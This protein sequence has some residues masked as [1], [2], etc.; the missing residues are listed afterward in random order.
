[1][2]PGLSPTIWLPTYIPVTTPA[3]ILDIIPFQ[4]PKPVAGS[5]GTVCWV[6]W[7]AASPRA[8]PVHH[9]T[10]APVGSTPRLDIWLTIWRGLTYGR[11]GAEPDLTAPPTGPACTLPA[12]VQCSRRPAAPAPPTMRSRLLGTPHA[13]TPCC[14]TST[15]AQHM[16]SA[17]RHSCN[18]QPVAQYW[19]AVLASQHWP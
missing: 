3:L 11:Q 19:T 4:T 12:K 15:T 17:R 18:V 13:T 5:E 8:L 6:K 1:M 2:V 16:F 9:A 10:Q 7:A 14:S